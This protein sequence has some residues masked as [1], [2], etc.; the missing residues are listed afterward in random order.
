MRRD[1][2]VLDGARNDVLA[3]VVTRRL[4]GHVARQLLV[5]VLR[6]KNVDAHAGQRH[7]GA[8]RH[9][10]RVG[11][12]FKKFGH[13]A[14][15]I[16]GH[17]AKGAGLAARHGN[18]ADGA[19]AA[20]GHM[21]S[22]HQ[23]I[24]HFVDMVTGQHHDVISAVAF[25]NVMVLVHGVRRAPVPA[26]VVVALLGGQ[27]IDELVHLGFQESPAALQMPQQAVRLVLRNDADA[28]DAGVQAIRQ[29]KINDAELAAEIDRWLGPAVGQVHQA[30]ATAT[31]Q[32]QSHGPLGQIKTLGKFVRVHFF[33]AMGL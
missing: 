19:V 1:L 14:V 11:G 31:G 23:G 29:R 5:E 9:G 16:D 12:F 24:V 15:F 18:A 30:T 13:H 20:L 7:V 25:Q 28:P 4:V 33:L 32:H 6:I 22:Q 21:V 3:K 26:F 10:G 8:A 27:Q 17:D 2:A